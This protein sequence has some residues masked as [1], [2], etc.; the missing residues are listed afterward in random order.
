MAGFQEFISKISRKFSRGRD[1][2]IDLG[3]KNL[4]IAE[5]GVGVVVNEPSVVA[6]DAASRE[7]LA[8]GVKASTMLDRTGSNVVARRPMKEGTINDLELAKKMLRYFMEQATDT[9]F[10]AL[11]APSNWAVVGVP[12]DTDDVHKN[13]Y[14]EL[15]TY[16]GIAELGTVDEVYAA[17]IGSGL[18]VMEPKG[19]MV[20]DIGGGTTDIA[21][22]SNGAI[23]VKKKV[24]VAGDS[25]DRAIRDFIRKNKD[26]DIS[27]AQAERI[28]QEIGGAIPLEDQEPKEITGQ[29]LNKRRPSKRTVTSDDIVE[30][31]K[32]PV[33]EIIN[34][35]LATLEQTPAA[36]AEDVYRDGVNLAGGGSKLR[37]LDT[38]V[39]ELTE[40]PV[41]CVKD[42]DNAVIKGLEQ[43][44]NNTVESR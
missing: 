36:L 17:A 33:N 23:V 6:V 11:S 13:A 42:P 35:I 26:L 38:R 12:V 41:N 20:V 3:T 34:N 39:E 7:V 30:A 4:I 29:D 43:I 5:Y 24:R 44:M 40:L 31:L 25:M 28:K 21:I 37:G 10:R 2:A 8:A 22:I 19:R 32:G 14:N 1:F 9:R 27:L 16:A 15:G 18:Q